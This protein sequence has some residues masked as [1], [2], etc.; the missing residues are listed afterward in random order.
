ME[1]Y[2]LLVDQK[3]ILLATDVICGFSIIPPRIPVSVLIEIEKLI[4]KFIWKCKVCRIVN[5]VRRLIVPDFKTCYEAT[6]TISV[7]LPSR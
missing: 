6:V 3:T 4:L 1:K 2:I 7:V 5:K